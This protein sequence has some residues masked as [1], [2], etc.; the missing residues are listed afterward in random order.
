MPNKSESKRGQQRGQNGYKKP[1]KYSE[2]QPRRY[3]EK[4]ESW[5]CQICFTEHPNSQQFC[6]PCYID[7]H[8]YSYV[9]MHMFVQ[10]DNSYQ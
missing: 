4:P 5:R 3:Y 7:L 1:R 8:Y 9:N 6:I 2:Q 10:S